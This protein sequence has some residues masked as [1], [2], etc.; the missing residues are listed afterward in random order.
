MRRIEAQLCRTASATLEAV[1]AMY[2][3]EA[4]CEILHRRKMADG[5]RPKMTAKADG[6]SATI[7]AV[8]E[9]NAYWRSSLKR[10]PH[11]PPPTIS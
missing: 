9:L 6:E 8:G 1:L 10:V 4:P 5:N 7:L 3:A 11:R 2:V